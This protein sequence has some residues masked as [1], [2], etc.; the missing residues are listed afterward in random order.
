M[1]T[2]IVLGVSGVEFET[3]KTTF[4]QNLFFNWSVWIFTDSIF[5]DL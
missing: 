3:D 5:S 4:K 2:E 1:K